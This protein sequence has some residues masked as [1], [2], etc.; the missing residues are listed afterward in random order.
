MLNTEDR[1]Y[2]RKAFFYGVLGALACNLVVL[3]GVFSYFTAAE[4]K[5]QLT[6]FLDIDSSR[7]PIVTDSTG[8]PSSV[9][10]VVEAANPAVVSIV[11]TK[12]VPVLESNPF[13]NFFSFPVPQYREQGTER[14]EIGGGS[15]FLVSPDGYIVTNAHVVSDKQA[16]YTV[17]LND[18]T[19][20]DAKVIA[21]D[22]ILDIALLK[23]DEKNLPYLEFGD[24]DKIKVGQEVVAIG[25]ALG[26]FRNTVSVGV[27]SGLARSV[28]A[29]TGV[30]RPEILSDVIQ[31]DAAINLGNSG[32]PLLDL[33]GRV[34][35]VN[36]AAS[37]GSA[38][39]IGFSLPANAVKRAVDSMRLNGKV[40][41]VY[42]GVRYIPVT[43]ELARQN[44]LAVEYGALLVRGQTEIEIAIAGGSPAEKVGLKEGDII[45]SVNGEKV[46][47]DMPL[48]NLL[49][50]Y[51]VGEKI[52]LR[53]LSSGEEKDVTATLEE[54]KG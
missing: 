9:V 29:S 45:L 41:R 37:V 7:P 14:Q 26:E 32:G 53:V 34:I 50:D 17:F 24:S 39:N 44:D 47:P 18:G 52:V 54:M 11:I 16:D 35:G 13:G 36:V 10:S 27:V 49:H 40:S 4:G 43:K 6:D 3:L 12:D 25:N 20:H 15:G 51:S 19:S 8:E 48:E 42:L 38:E 2:F 23:I 1:E 5:A 31:T 28:S 46:T 22:T 33:S 30:G 21:A